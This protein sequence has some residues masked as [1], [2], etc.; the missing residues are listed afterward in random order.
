[1]KRVLIVDDSKI[2]RA[3]IRRNLDTLGFEA[4]ISEAEDG[5]QALALLQQ[6][7]VDLIFADVRMP[8]M[9]GVGLVFQLNKSP[10]LSKIPVSMVSSDRSN[11]RVAKLLDAGVCAYLM[12]PFR[13]EALRDALNKALGELHV[14]I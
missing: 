10:E 8:N 2:V 3:M 6:A 4:E 14:G 12:K 11:A 1:M 9:S 13:P 5:A 7:P